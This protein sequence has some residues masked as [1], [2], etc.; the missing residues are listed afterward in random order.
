MG[1]F[2]CLALELKHMKIPILIEPTA[3]QR[4]RATG[5]SPLVGSVEADTPDEAVEKLRELIQDRVAKGAQIA[6]I[7]LP[8]GVD[9]WLAGAGMFRD[10][11][12]YDD[13][14]QAIA[15]YRREANETSDAP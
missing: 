9:P 12:L 11:P 8:D 1:Q 2:P 14:Q 5:G 6:S 15:G 3:D 4:F 10:D 7:E 13:W